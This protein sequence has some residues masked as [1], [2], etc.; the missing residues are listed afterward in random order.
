MTGLLLWI[1]GATLVVGG[2]ALFGFGNRVAGTDRFFE[3]AHPERETGG[4][5]HRIA[6]LRRNPFDVLAWFER[7]GWMAPE[8][9]SWYLLGL[10]AWLL[11]VVVAAVAGAWGL[12][13]G[14]GA[15][16]VLLLMLA[17]RRG[18]ARREAVRNQV[19]ALLDSLMR[20][21]EVGQTVDSAFRMS[22]ESIN[23]PIRPVLQRV[24]MRV[25]L[26]ESLGEAFRHAARV[27][28][29]RELHLLGFILTMHQQHGGKASEMLDG[30][31]RMITVDQQMKRDLRAMTA[32]TRFTALV[33][34]ALPIGMAAYLL[35]M[36][37]DYLL[38][39]WEHE[40]GRYVLLLAA[41]MQVVGSVLIWRL[42]N[43][44]TG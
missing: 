6:P 12:A 23:G 22:A 28:D 43:P 16:L 37:P 40:T 11:L 24:R 41:A 14:V 15:A 36:S 19:T 34:I 27:Q 13:L 35:A 21:L 9:R 8:R 31:S 44:Q 5:N 7:A 4:S 1:V 25:D 42:S 38:T 26:G 29:I 32:E 17:W 2:A 20:G 10:S 39:M 30:L 3:R 18:R 33:L